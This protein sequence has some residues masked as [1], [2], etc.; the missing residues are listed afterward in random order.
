MP[1]KSRRAKGRARKTRRAKP[2]PKGG[3][4]DA[5]QRLVSIINNTPAKPTIINPASKF[6]VV[7]YWWGR[8]NLNKNTQRPCPED[9]SDPV[10]E[11]FMESL[12]EDDEE[13]QGLFN[14]YDAAAR[15]VKEAR[16]TPE[17]PSD[18]QRA[19][20]TRTSQEWTQY[21][22]NWFSRP[23][24]KAKFG[25]KVKNAT[26]A[27]RMSNKF[28]EPI[29]FEEMI[30]HYENS[31]RR[32][33]CNYLAVE[34]PEFAQPGGYQLAINAKPLFIQRALDVCQ[35]RG[36]LYIDGDMFI[37]KYP[38]IFDLPNIDFMARGW[39]IDP[40]SSAKY[41]DVVCFD[42][43]IFETS[44]GTMF[45]ADTPMS[46][47]LLKG[48]WDETSL[49]QSQGKADD[50]ILS[51]V[52]TL[53]KYP[54]YSNSIQLPMEY[55]WLTDN[56]T[57]RAGLDQDA[58]YAEVIIEHPECLTGEERAAEISTGVSNRE[59]EGY[60]QKITNLTECERS[61]GIFYEY[62]FFPT[63]EDVSAFGPYLAYM[64]SAKNKD[65]E[66]MFKVVSYTDK[67]GDFSTVA[68]DNETAAASETVAEEAGQTAQLPATATP[69]QILAR[70]KKGVHVSVGGGTELP[71]VE[72]VATFLPT[73]KDAYINRIKIDVTKPMFIAAGN[74][75]LHHLFAMSKT[76]EDINTHLEK[77][78]V[79]LSR[80]RWSTPEGPFAPDN[81][82]PAEPEGDP[83]SAKVDL[84]DMGQQFNLSE[85]PRNNV[86]VPA[87]EPVA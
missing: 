78:Y 54:I 43:Y 57:G 58:P 74:P 22:N 19:T 52:F 73:Q 75:I 46:R 71:N 1:P 11:A 40:R 17:G 36:V 38:R 82:P 68:T 55:L 61:G 65:G 85:G 13:A 41:K 59:P 28:C 9:V 81:S 60:Q 39:N 30:R 63:A 50:R 2:V 37:N 67:Y 12:A 32:F 64:K 72:C 66:P 45:F 84:D 18:E 83:N 27:L 20:L 33:N 35:G 53:Q 34:Y 29:L 23:N 3:A 49:P 47:R 42:P 21:F 62:V 10:K 79:F 15:A 76:L 5:N 14:A 70:L 25:D 51:V 69:A 87:E 6:V 80:V 7:T 26:D 16:K 77:S 4:E 86:S 8:G 24:I 48:W 31:C 56:Y 44:G